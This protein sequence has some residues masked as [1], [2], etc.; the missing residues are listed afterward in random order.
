MISE[1]FSHYDVRFLTT[2]MNR[3]A[4]QT[5]KDL[6]TVGDADLSTKLKLMPLA[7]QVFVAVLKHRPN[8]VISTGAAPGFFAVLFGRFI[9]A[10]TIWVDSMANHSNLSV[11]GRY[12]SKF[13]HLCVTQWKDLATGEK[14]KYFG[15]LL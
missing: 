14:I 8:V 3:S 10:K 13:C 7:L 2:T 6:I 15:S 11:S 1:A 5:H 4:I 9:G 12:A